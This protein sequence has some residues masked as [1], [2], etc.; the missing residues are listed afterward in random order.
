MIA[1][2]IALFVCF[3]LILAVRADTRLNKQTEQAKVDISSRISA[4]LAAQGLTNWL[5][6]V[7]YEDSLRAQVVEFQPPD[8]QKAAKVIPF[9]ITLNSDS[10]L[11]MNEVHEWPTKMVHLGNSGAHLSQ[12]RLV[13]SALQARFLDRLGGKPTQQI[14]TALIIAA[15]PGCESAFDV[16]LRA[17]WEKEA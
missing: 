4:V 13:S 16:D 6:Q 1:L 17:V 3:G 14:G 10:Y 11:A 9:S 15:P 12:V 5:Q 2:R 8:C 7:A